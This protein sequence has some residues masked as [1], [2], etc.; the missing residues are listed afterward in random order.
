MIFVIAA[1]GTGGHVMPGLA[2]AKELR[3][4]GHDA[5]F[6][7]T[8]KG[9]EAI[10]AP[11]AG[12]PL[13]L[14]KVGALKQV[15]WA[16]RMKTLLELPLS[17]V[18]AAKMLDRAQ[19]RAVFSMG[20]YAAGPVTLMAIAK[21]IPVVVMEPNAMPGFT[22]RVIGPFISKALLGFGEA[23]RFFPY[24]RAEV[25][26]IPIREE[27]F[28]IAPKRH[29]A[30]FIVLI[31]GG[32]QGSHRLNE[33]GPEAAALAEQTKWRGRIVFLHQAGK[34]EYND[35]CFRYQKAGA[36]AEVE[37]FIE[38]MPGAFARADIVVCRAGAST[39][40]ELS[41]A[42]K[43]SILV[44]FPFAADQH[45]LHN[46]RSM[47]AAGAGSLIEDSALSG[48]RLFEEL[49]ALL[50]RPDRLVEMEAAARKLARPGAAQRAADILE[51]I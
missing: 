17:F 30:P 23:K 5:L 15:S 48:R 20:G 27:F 28:H 44:P 40:A 7:G 8:S 39:V 29:Q 10:L 1:G 47:Q 32:S 12:F 42:G 35:V 18:D 33:A 45:Q 22:N 49:Q 21:G 34:N 25:T 13:H 51:Q 4:R 26:G 6:V 19:P 14:L 2:V 31:T 37:P 43:A 11:Q 24:G 16:R 41:A 3:K 38:N 9:M 46:A 36:R 50:E